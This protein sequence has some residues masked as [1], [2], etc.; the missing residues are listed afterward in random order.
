[1]LRDGRLDEIGA[2]TILGDLGEIMTDASVAGRYAALR[3]MPLP[4][5]AIQT[6]NPYTSGDIMDRDISWSDE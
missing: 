6:S 4:K 2:V 5:R 3:D 1:M